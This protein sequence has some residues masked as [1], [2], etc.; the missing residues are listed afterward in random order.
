[1]S[2]TS[3]EGHATGTCISILFSCV[4][5]ISCGVSSVIVCCFPA[6]FC[7]E[8]V[9]EKKKKLNWFTETRCVWV[10][11]QTR[12]KSTVITA[13][14]TAQQL[15]VAL[16]DISLCCVGTEIKCNLSHSGAAHTNTRGEGSYRYTYEMYNQ[17]IYNLPNYLHFFKFA[18]RNNYQQIKIK[19]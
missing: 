10:S 6:A 13:V 4:S 7:A 8:H 5:L 1:M 17:S 11:A 14:V 9:G 2:L 18:V 12:K 19:H 16:R 15:C 3:F